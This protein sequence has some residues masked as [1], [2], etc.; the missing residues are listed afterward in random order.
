MAFCWSSRVFISITATCAVFHLAIYN[1][2][3]CLIMIEGPR[4]CTFRGNTY[5]HGQRFIYNKAPCSEYKCLY[6]RVFD[7]KLQCEH[8]KVCYGVRTQLRI[9]TS[10]RIVCVVNKKLMEPYWRRFGHL[11]G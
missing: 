1:V 11:D 5:T 3:S 6:G 8:N 4:N 10:N 7:I 2:D 9:S